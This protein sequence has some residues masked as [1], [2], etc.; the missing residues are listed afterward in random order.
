M[1][2]MDVVLTPD[3][4]TKFATLVFGEDA[5]AKYIAL[6]AS[7]PDLSGLEKDDDVTTVYIW[8]GHERL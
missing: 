8:R 5:G 6:S 4:F 7:H 2:S 1:K 3:M